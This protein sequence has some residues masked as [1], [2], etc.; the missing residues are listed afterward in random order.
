MNS[1]YLRIAILVLVDAA[2]VAFCSIVPLALRFGIFTMDVTYLEPAI[3]CLPADIVITIGVL[4]A[5]RLYNRVWSYA[6]IDEML[7]VFKASLVIEALYVVY[8]IFANVDMPRSFY[9]FNWVF[10][11]VL[12]AGSRVSIRVWRQFRRKYEKTETHRNVTVSYTH[13]TLPTT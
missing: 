6:G 8:Q 2:I 7:S 13:L 1:K 4:A 5:F 11:F 9:I 12:L 3:K 10:L